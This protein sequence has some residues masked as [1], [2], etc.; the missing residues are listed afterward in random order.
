M[1]YH[2]RTLS[3]REETA[4]T[5]LWK[6]VLLQILQDAF[7]NTYESKERSHKRHARDYMKFLHKDFAQVCQYAG[8]DPSFVHRKVIK[9]LNQEFLTKIGVNYVK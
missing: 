5:K 3:H 6:A 2:Q 9:K 1:S 8:Y 4:E 7:S